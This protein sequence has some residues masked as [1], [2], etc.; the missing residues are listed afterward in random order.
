MSNELLV[1][2]VELKRLM[3]KAQWSPAYTLLNEI[4]RKVTGEPPIIE[5][6][7]NDPVART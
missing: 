2:L 3:H 6:K 4:I 5:A 7:K 1:D